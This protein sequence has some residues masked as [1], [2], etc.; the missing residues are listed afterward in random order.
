MTLELYTDDKN[1][2]T[3]ETVEAALSSAGLV[4]TRSEVYIDSERMYMVTYTTEIIITEE[5]SNE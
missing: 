1:Y 3:E 4:F 5:V 2:T